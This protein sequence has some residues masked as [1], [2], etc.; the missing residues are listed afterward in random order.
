MSRNPLPKHLTDF[1]ARRHRLLQDNWA[2]G[3]RCGRLLPPSQHLSPDNFLRLVSL[4]GL[5][6]RRALPYSHEIHVHRTLLHWHY[7]RLLAYHGDTDGATLLDYDL[8]VDQSLFRDHNRLL[9]P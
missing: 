2:G 3:L 7:V 5:L 6:G 4:L 9:F 8:A 1:H